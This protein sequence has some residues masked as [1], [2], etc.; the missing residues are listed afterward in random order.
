[1]TAPTR[2]LAI[3]EP[4]RY[5]ALNRVLRHAHRHVPLYR[6]AWSGIAAPEMQLPVVRQPEELRRFPVFS[7]EDLAAAPLE[8]RCDARW[9]ARLIHLERS[10]GS[11]GTPLVVPVDV[12]SL[13]RRQRRFLRGLRECGYRLGDRM[14][15]LTTRATG[16]HPT[17]PGVFCVDLRAPAATVVRLYHQVRPRVLY[18]PLN[19]LLMLVDALATTPGHRRPEVVVSTAEAMST[20]QRAELA[21]AFGADP[22]DFYGSSEAGLVAW[23]R[24]GQDTYRFPGRDFLIELLPTQAGALC[25]LVLTDLR[26]GGCSPLVRYDTGD[27]VET[28]AAGGAVARVHG[29][30]MDCLTRPDGVLVSP[31]RVTLVLE[32]MPWIARYQVVQRADLSVDLALWGQAVAEPERQARV[33]AAL[34]T[35]I[36]AGVPIRVHPQTDPPARAH[37]KFRPVRSEAAIHAHS[38]T[39]L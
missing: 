12:L 22:A 38:D 4:R 13:W 33:L 15:F 1:M 31:Y 23:R 10:G 20:G 14:M 7:R 18:G 17:V 9:P 27:V 3:D 36:G 35:V 6:E 26:T 5:R 25:R 32:D 21:L 37:R 11:T 19:S 30:L 39:L 29:R 8:Q 34:R 28:E 16:P 24:P 2:V